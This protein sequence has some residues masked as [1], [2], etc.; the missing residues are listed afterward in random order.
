MRTAIK[1]DH[2]KFAI[3]V[4]KSWIGRPMFRVVNQILLLI[5]RCINNKNTTI[6]FKNNRHNK[7]ISWLNLN[8]RFKSLINWQK[9]LRKVAVIWSWQKENWLLYT[10]AICIDLVQFC[11]NWDTTH[12]YCKILIIMFTILFYSRITMFTILFY[13]NHVYNII[14]L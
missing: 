8:S 11:T 1:L 4:I 9:K 10:R 13:D 2:I 3:M 7:I 12:M 14:L 5:I 6:K